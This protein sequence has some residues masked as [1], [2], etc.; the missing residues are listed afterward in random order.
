MR[1]V[2][3]METKD[4]TKKIWAF[5]LGDG[6]LSTTKSYNLV[7]ER[8]H[9]RSWYNREK[10]SHY[11]LKQREDHKDYIDWQAN[12]L[13]Q[14]TS[15][16][17][18]YNEPYVD[19]RGYAIKGQYELHTK[20]HPIYTTLRN[21]IYL[22][23]VKCVSEHDLH[24]LDWECMAIFYMDD[25]WIDVQHFS[26]GPY[27]RLAIASHNYTYGD[28]LMLK[29]AIKEKLGIEFNIQKHLQKSGEYKF[30]LKTKKDHAKRFLD[31]IAKFIVPSYEYKLFSAQVAPEKGDDIV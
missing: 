30:Y 8:K 18:Q 12:Y 6:G 15:V 21:R 23:G 22:N 24:L 17:V 27:I 13:E 1:C 14:L 5:T 29:E 9:E 7:E 19:K 16:R 28:Q 11:Y 3:T 31:G 10:N 20:T 25:G 26:T 2:T 4:F